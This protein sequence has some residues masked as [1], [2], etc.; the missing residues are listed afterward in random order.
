MRGT[1]NASS[2]NQPDGSRNG[3]DASGMSAGLTVTLSRHVYGT[4]PA[5][6]LIHSGMQA[7]EFAS[8]SNA[9]IRKQVEE[10]EANI[11]QLQVAVHAVILHRLL[12]TSV[13]AQIQDMGQRLGRVM[14]KAST[15]MEQAQVGYDKAVLNANMFVIIC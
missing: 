2:S 10:K 12:S 5:C 6:S 8:G 3:G 13:Q 14:L 11:V 9:T 1:G 7:V 4:R 15:A